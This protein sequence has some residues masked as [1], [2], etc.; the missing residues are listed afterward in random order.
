[1]SVSVHLLSLAS[2]LGAV[3]FATISAG[4][5]AGLM[6]A[7]VAFAATLGWP[8]GGV[9]PGAT[10]ATGLVAAAAAVGALTGRM[11][12]EILGILAGWLAASWALVLRAEGLPLWAAAVLALAIPCLAALGSRRSSFAPPRLCE[13]ALALVVL[14]GVCAAAAP[15]LSEGW[16]AAVNLKFGGVAPTAAAVPGWAVAVSLTALAAGAGY[17][18]WSRRH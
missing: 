3:V 15:G 14:L 17:S 13:D 4:S 9:V 7:G 1:M 10:G 18:A 16:R 12:I 8:P 5:R 2:A 6:L 11:R